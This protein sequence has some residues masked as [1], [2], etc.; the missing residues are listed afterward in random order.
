MKTL[1]FSLFFLIT[2]ILINNSCAI[3]QSDAE[4]I[5]TSKNL[6][7][8][9]NCEEAFNTAI[10]VENKFNEK[11]QE[12]LVEAYPCIIK[13][14]FKE[15]YTYVV[16]PDDDAKSQLIKLYKF[17]SYLDKNVQT[18]SIFKKY[19][20]LLDYNTYTRSKSIQELITSYNEKIKF[21]KEKIVSDSIAAITK[22]NEVATTKSNTVVNTTKQDT[23]ASSTTFISPDTTTTKEKYY[24]IAGSYQTEALAQNAVDKLKA[25]G[26]SNAAVVGKNDYGSYRICYNSFDDK[27]SATSELSKIKT[28]GISSVWLLTTNANTNSATVETSTTHTNSSNNININQK[29]DK[30]KYKIVKASDTVLTEGIY[31]IFYNSNWI[32]IDSSASASYYR[33]IKINASGIPFDTVKDYYAES[34]KLQWKGQ[35]SKLDLQNRKKNVLEGV[36]IVYNSSGHIIDITYYKKGD[37]LWTTNYYSGQNNTTFNNGLCKALG[38]DQNTDKHGFGFIDNNGNIIIPFQYTHSSTGDFS[39]GLASVA[40]PGTDIFGYIDTIGNVVIPYQFN[41]AG[42]FNDNR[43]A[44]QFEK[45]DKWGFINRKGEMVIPS[46][47]DEVRS[48]KNN[49]CKVFLYSDTIYD[50]VTGWDGTIYNNPIGYLLCYINTIGIMKGDCEYIKNEPYWKYYHKKN[51]YNSVT[52]SNG[53]YEGELIDGKRNGYGTYTWDNGDKYEGEWKNDQRNGYGTYYYKNGTTASGT[54]VDGVLQ[55]DNT[56]V[57]NTTKT[58]SIGVDD[59]VDGLLNVQ[60]NVNSQNN[61]GENNTLTNISNDNT[62]TQMMPIKGCIGLYEMNF[63]SLQEDGYVIIGSLAHQ[64]NLPIVGNR[65]ASVPFKGWFLA[66]DE[67]GGIAVGTLAIDYNITP[68]GQ[69]APIKFMEDCFI[70]FKEG[71]VTQGQIKYSLTF[72]GVQYPAGTNLYFKD[73]GSAEINTS[74][75]IEFH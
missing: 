17:K 13:K 38:T 42:S 66:N 43:A 10:T 74:P 14:N 49:E 28:N 23:S 68:C 7:S 57:D 58:Y 16:Y 31:K 35:M 70:A 47:Y 5:K 71:C 15:A 44:V 41:S 19:V 45:G 3:A 62:T 11:M 72:K 37:D 6:L 39:E 64:T 33:I 12:L 60:N 61:V 20:K 32:I 4:I 50:S 52:L 55:S 22:K 26:Y 24:L 59:I 2:L 25:Q 36:C 56:S 65:M 63:L 53:G 18:D 40:K 27:A 73:D 46:I 1:M 48:F 51:G 54:W 75:E 69:V 30:T 29:S 9:N 8:S 34:N 67:E 21:I